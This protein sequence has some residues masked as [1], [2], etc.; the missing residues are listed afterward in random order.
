M[1]E[2]KPTN[3]PFDTQSFQKIKP[4]NFAEQKVLMKRGLYSQA[5]FKTKQTKILRSNLKSKQW[6]VSTQLPRVPVRQ[7]S[8]SD[9]SQETFAQRKVR[10]SVALPKREPSNQTTRTF[11][12][13]NEM[14]VKFFDEILNKGLMILPEIFY[15]FFHRPPACDIRVG[16]LSNSLPVLQGDHETIFNDIL[17]ATH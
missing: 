8:F 4:K 6:A 15:I 2:N 12:E 7:K 14:E 1:N 17:F 5:N 10:E 3:F 9:V 16:Q 13:G 11:Q